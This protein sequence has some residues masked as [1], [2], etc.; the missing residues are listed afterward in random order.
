M[1][2]GWRYLGYSGETK[3]FLEVLQVV[4]KDH[5]LSKEI[6]GEEWAEL[7]MHDCENYP[8]MQ[9][10][11]DSLKYV[12]LTILGKVPG[13]RPKEGDVNYVRRQLQMYSQIQVSRMEDLTSAEKASLTEKYRSGIVRMWPKLKEILMRNKGLLELMLSGGGTQSLTFAKFPV[14]LVPHARALESAWGYNF[15]NAGVYRRL[16]LYDISARYSVVEPIFAELRRRTW[17]AQQAIKEVLPQPGTTKPGEKVARICTLGAGLLIEFRK[18]GMTLNDIKRLDV[19]ACD[20]DRTLKSDLDTVLQFDYGASIEDTGI[21]YR[22]CD[23]TDVLSDRSL[24]G[25]VDVVLMDGVLS[26]CRD[27]QAMTDYVAGMKKLLSKK[28]T[29]VCDL[30]VMDPSLIRCAFVHEWKSSMKPER[31]A[32]K[33]IDKMKRI[34]RNVGLEIEVSVDDRNPRPLGVVFKLTLPTSHTM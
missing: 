7:A 2:E 12:F 6:F 32:R 20:A 33:A 34:C 21:D 17:I 13:F 29:I 28:G 8:P 5:Y 18:Y 14:D 19:I 26:Y 24:W 23:I 22:F 10:W 4:P 16:D 11:G 1:C 30:Q 25:T 15:D 27:E 3:Y 31:S 9:V